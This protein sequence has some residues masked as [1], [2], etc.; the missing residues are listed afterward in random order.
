MVPGA[1]VVPGGTSLIRSVVSPRIGRDGG[2]LRSV[3]M[4]VEITSKY[5]YPLLYET[6]HAIAPFYHCAQSICIGIVEVLGVPRNVVGSS[7]SSRENP[8]VQLMCYNPY[9]GVEVSAE[10]VDVG[11]VFKCNAGWQRAARLEFRFLR[12]PFLNQRTQEIEI[13]LPNIFNDFC[14][15]M[16]VVLAYY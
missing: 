5:P 15:W 2:A 8:V 7:L 12:S 4:I 6:L 14:K 3:M 1:C 16:V 9:S 10:K 11:F 13:R